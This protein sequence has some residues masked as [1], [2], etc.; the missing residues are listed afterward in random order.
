MTNKTNMSILKVFK[1][2]FVIFL[3]QIS[4]LILTINL[5]DYKYNLNL[6]RLP[7]P[8]KTTEEQIVIIKWL[9]N[10]ILYE[11]W[12]DLFFMCTIWLLISIIPVLIYNNYKQAYSMNLLTL[13]FPNFFL[14]AFLQNYY[15]PYFDKNFLNLFIKTIILGITILLFSIGLS[16]ALKVIRRSKSDIQQEDLHLIAESIRSKCPQCGTEF[17]SRPKICYNCNTD[18]TIKNGDKFI[19]T[20]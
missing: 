1:S 10:Y 8:T 13:F 7:K 3:I 5:F 9:A 20:E 11:D 2:R 4:I 16:L 15:R 19:D 18:L 14:Y 6:L 17:E 12:N